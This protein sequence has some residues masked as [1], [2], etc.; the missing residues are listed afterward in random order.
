MAQSANQEQ[1]FLPLDQSG[2]GNFAL[3]VIKGYKLFF[4]NQRLCEMVVTGECVD[5]TLW[6]LILLAVQMNAFEQNFFDL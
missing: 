5:R 4:L 2:G 6:V 1:V 3:Y